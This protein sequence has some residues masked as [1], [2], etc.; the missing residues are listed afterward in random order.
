MGYGPFIAEPYFGH[1]SRLYQIDLYDNP[2]NIADVIVESYNMGVRAINLINDKNL[3][4]GYE[5]AADCGCEMKVIATIGKSDVDYLN[6]NYE[7]AKEADWD[8]DIDF[9]SS[10]DC[11]AMLVDEFIVDGYDWKLTSKILSRINETGSVSG[12]VTAFPSKTTDLLKDNI[13]MGLFDLYMIPYNSLSYMMDISAFNKK[14]R[15]EFIEK[16]VDL[17]KKIIA[18]R[19]FAVGVL[20]PEDSFEFYKNVDFVDAITLGVASKDEAKEDFSLLS[21]Y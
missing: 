7:I 12:L 14:Q 5:I 4:E 11:P 19:V 21:K 8:E 13:D 20:K 3:I 6:P 2:H 9:F 1:R 17:N 10:Y 15:N 16:I 18:T